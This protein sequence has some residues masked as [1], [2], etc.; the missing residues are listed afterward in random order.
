MP[1]ASIT[2]SCRTIASTGTFS[3]A[4]H[5]LDRAEA[6]VEDVEDV[7]QR[8]PHG[9][10]SHQGHHG[11]AFEIGRDGPAGLDR[12][13]DDLRADLGPCP[14]QVDRGD[15]FDQFALEVLDP[16]QFLFGVL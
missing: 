4:L 16:V 3:W 1:A 7:D 13:A 2:S 11:D 14:V 10:P 9:Q 15:A 12:L 8:Q 6:V 5:F